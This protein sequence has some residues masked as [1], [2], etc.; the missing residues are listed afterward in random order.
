MKKALYFF[1][2]AVLLAATVFYVKSWINVK[3]YYPPE[4]VHFRVAS[5]EGDKVALFSI[6]YQTI[7]P[8]IP[9]DVEPYAYLTVLDAKTGRVVLRKTKYE[10]SFQYAFEMLSKSHAPWATDKIESYDRIS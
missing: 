2:I 6:R 7:H 3:R 10:P 1:T 4:Q 8:L 5:P 9:S